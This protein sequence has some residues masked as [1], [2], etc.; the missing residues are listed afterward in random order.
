MKYF[1]NVTA[2]INDGDYVEE[3]NEV[4]ESDLINILAVCNVLKDFKRNYS[5]NWETGKLE[6]KKTPEIL[7]IQTG[8][9]T[10]EQVEIFYE[11]IPSG[12]EEYPG[13]HT[14]KEVKIFYVSNVEEFIFE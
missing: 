14:I 10:L 3:M 2:D 7:Y 8:L 13:I 6:R 4:K 1:I 12:D 9:L 5:H 11:F